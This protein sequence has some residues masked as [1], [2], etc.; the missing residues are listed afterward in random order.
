MAV[1]FTMA[2]IG[3]NQP[4]RPD[5]VERLTARLVKIGKL[6]PKHAMSYE[7]REYMNFLPNT[8]GPQQCYAPAPMPM[9][10]TPARVPGLSDALVAAII[11]VQNHFMLRPDVIISSGGTTARYLGNWEV[12]TIAKN[13]Q[14]P[15]RL[16]E[17]WDLV[18]PLLPKG[19]YCS[20]GYRSS[21]RQRELLHN[22]FNVT[23]KAD[24]IAKYG[25]AA[26]DAAATNLVANEAKVLEMVRG[27]GQA[28]ATPGRSAH[29]QSKAIDVGGPSTID[30][31]QVK[32]IAQVARANPHLLSGKVLKERNGCVHFEIR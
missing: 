15:G 1:L 3:V 4:N 22:F 9:G 29:Q 17:A 7:R 27:V 25:Q 13:V 6:S 21:E 14:L 32:V 23:Y 5:D 10:M 26:Y 30:N 8:G 11:S 12:K 31:E 28:I 20:S 18:N 24:I 2:G 16:R 19:S